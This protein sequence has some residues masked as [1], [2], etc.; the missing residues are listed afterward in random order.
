MKNIF[1]ISRADLRGKKFDYNSY[2][3]SP[4]LSLQIT[5]VTM[6]MKTLQAI[7]TLI[8]GIITT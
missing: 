3:Y 4:E 2:Y 8:F 7:F 5:L 1:D 6:M